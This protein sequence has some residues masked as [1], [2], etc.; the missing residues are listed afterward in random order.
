MTTLI[1]NKYIPLEK[2]S[3]PYMEFKQGFGYV[4]VTLMDAESKKIQCHLCGECF[5]MIHFHA[6]KV[7][8]IKASEYKKL[9]G[10]NASNPLTSP[11]LREV[12]SE[13][14]TNNPAYLEAVEKARQVRKQLLKQGL[15][16]RGPAKGYKKAHT[17]QFQNR[18]NI[19]DAQL[20]DRFDKLSAELGKTPSYAECPFAGVMASRFG[21]WNEAVSAMGH[22]PRKRVGGPST[23]LT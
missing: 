14:R 11:R 12:F 6:W 2:G 21:G 22:T 1:N 19:C 20:K 17:P 18:Y 10:L 5:D 13:R 15:G 9:A 8:K 7:H 23:K 16:R 4:G 3:P